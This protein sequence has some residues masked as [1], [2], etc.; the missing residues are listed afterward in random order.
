VEFNIIIFD[1]VFFSVDVASVRDVQRLYIYVA[2]KVDA[3]CKSG[4]VLIYVVTT[5]RV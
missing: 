4:V 3:S 1:A 5:A 2:S